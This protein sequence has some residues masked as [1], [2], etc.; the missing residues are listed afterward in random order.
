MEGTFRIVGDI[1]S[2]VV[3]ESDWEVLNDP[4]RVFRGS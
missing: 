3:P 4:E 2:P 1:I